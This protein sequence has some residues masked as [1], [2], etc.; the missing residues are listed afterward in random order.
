[1]KSRKNEQTPNSKPE[2][3]ERKPVPKNFYREKFI[4]KF[5]RLLESLTRVFPECAATQKKYL[6]FCVAK[7][8]EEVC[9]KIIQEWHKTMKN[10]YEFAEAE[11]EIEFREQAQRIKWF[12]ELD[13][14]KKWDDP[15]FQKSHANMWK[16]LKILNSLAKMHCQI[17]GDVLDSAIGLAKNFL[18]QGGGDGKTDLLTAASSKMEEFNPESMQR[19]EENMGD[20][21]EEI[22]SSLMD[23]KNGIQKE[24]SLVTAITERLFQ[25]EDIVNQT[26]NMTEEDEK[27][28]KEKYDSMA[29]MVMGKA[30][31]C[32]LTQM[33]GKKFST[34]SDE[35]KD[36]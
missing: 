36:V 14:V 22:M 24:G 21:F 12:K 9:E 13:I 11:D 2:L 4:D 32:G 15:G 25:D 27:R 7:N 29:S 34:S 28:M 1:M 17:P 8:S 19:L 30:S 35:K 6:E 10:F 3:K 26:T 31:E 18:F 23:Q 5:G 33:M 20:I 16:N